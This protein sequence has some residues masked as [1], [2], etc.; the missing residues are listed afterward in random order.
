M[1]TYLYTF[2]HFDYRLCAFP[3]FRI[4]TILSKLQ[5]QKNR[6]FEDHLFTATSEVWW[7]IT[8]NSKKNIYLLS[9]RNGSVYSPPPHYTTNIDWKRKSKKNWNLY[10]TNLELRD[11][12]SLHSTLASFTD[13]EITKRS[14]LPYNTTKSPLFHLLISTLLVR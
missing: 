6:L 1:T 3:H 14:T 13:K 5:Q 8:D 11:F 2:S 10:R 12:C 4:F 7:V 9:S